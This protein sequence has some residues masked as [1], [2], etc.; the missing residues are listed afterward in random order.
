MV[1]KSQAVRIYSPLGRRAGLPADTL[2]E[3]ERYHQA[4]ARY[5]QRDWDVAAALF[6]ALHAAAPERKLYKL[7]LERIARLRDTGPAEEWDGAFT[8]ET[9]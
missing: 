9:K 6:D 1:G 4:L 8:A 5:H 2:A 7:Y 3:A